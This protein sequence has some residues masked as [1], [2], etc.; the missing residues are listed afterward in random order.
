[1][2]RIVNDHNGF[3]RVNSKENE[4]AKFTIELPIHVLHGKYI[5]RETKDDSAQKE[6][7]GNEK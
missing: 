7:N 2:K 4:G 3:I 5:E 1:M 6:T